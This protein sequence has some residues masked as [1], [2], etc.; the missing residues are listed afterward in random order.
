MAGLRDAD[1]PENATLEL[2][3]CP[4]THLEEVG[5]TIDEA[6]I[7]AVAS[8]FSNITLRT[9]AMGYAII[10]P[11][12]TDLKTK[13]YNAQKAA[14]VRGLGSQLVRGLSKS[15][16][17]TRSL[18][19]SCVHPDPSV[20]Q[21]FIEPKCEWSLLR[22]LELQHFS[23]DAQLFGDFTCK[24]IVH[25]ETMILS[26]GALT[27]ENGEADWRSL[28]ERWVSIKQSTIPSEWTLKTLRLMSL[29]DDQNRHFPYTDASN[30]VRSLVSLP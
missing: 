23:V 30:I 11:G 14:G 28:Y 21:P 6:L 10:K 12:T 5:F 18:E 27:S 17:H 19:I 16:S 29:I 26:N 20:T 9:R 4:I 8:K 25:L 15:G 7:E 24:V 2:L 13:P 1:I 3:N 22:R